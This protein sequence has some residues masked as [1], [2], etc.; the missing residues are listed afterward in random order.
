MP[1]SLF[2]DRSGYCSCACG[3]CYW[4]PM[5]G[6]RC[7]FTQPKIN[8]LLEDVLVV[9]QKLRSKFSHVDI[10][11]SLW[12]Y[13]AVIP[14]RL[15]KSDWAAFLP[16]HMIGTALEPTSSFGDVFSINIYGSVAPPHALRLTINLP[17]VAACIQIGSR[18]NQAMGSMLLYP[19]T[20]ANFTS[21][22]SMRELAV[23]GCEYEW[24]LNGGSGA[25]DLWI[26]I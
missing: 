8:Q 22:V 24:S 7:G 2:F 21:D 23:I 19:V 15:P 3:S 1:K 26:K 6:C 25:I 18:L 4:R 17:D 10:T 16:P 5:D 12:F 11:N 20:T 9:S 14:N 13:D